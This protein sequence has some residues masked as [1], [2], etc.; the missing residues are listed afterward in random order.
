M[1]CVYYIREK[2]YSVVDD[3]WEGTSIPDSFLEQCTA[4]SSWKD[5]I[6][7]RRSDIF[8]VPEDVD[9]SESS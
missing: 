4:D 8:K 6:R 3:N 5:C 7:Y 9:E 1:P 2:C